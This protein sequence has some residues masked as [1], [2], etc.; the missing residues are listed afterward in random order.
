MY[1]PIEVCFW[2]QEYHLICFLDKPDFGYVHFWF[3]NEISLIKHCHEIGLNL[4]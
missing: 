3:N 4:L 1:M 2:T